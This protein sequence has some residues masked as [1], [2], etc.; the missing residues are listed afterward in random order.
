MSMLGTPGAQEQD[1]AAIEKAEAAVVAVWL[2]APVTFRRALFVA[3]PPLG[4]G[5]YKERQGR[6]FGPGEPL[7]V[8]AEPVGY[9]WLEN[10]DATFTFGFA[11][12]LLVKTAAG[13]VV[14][15]Q[16]NFRRLE[17][18]SRARNRE[19]MLTLTLEIEG[20]PPGD[21]VLEY[22]TRDIASDKAGVISLPFTIRA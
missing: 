16:E 2:A 12:D 15:G 9:G 8:Y 4:F 3:E 22:R 13:K 1:L 11:V 20:A 5:I 7:V 21:Y 10:A 19:F 6:V 17:L 14:A 18:T